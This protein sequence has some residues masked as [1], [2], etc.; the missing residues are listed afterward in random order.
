MGNKQLIGGTIFFKID[1]DIYKAKG[2]FKYGAGKPERE[3]VVGVDGVHGY[4][5]KPTAPFIE[6][7]L[8]DH[9]DLSIDD[10]ANITESTI[11][12]DLAN[13]KTF[14]LKQ[15]WNCNKDGLSV[16]ADDGKIGVRF[17]GMQGEE[18]K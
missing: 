9:G 17:E 14:V 3:A 16:E 13:G 5:E 8:T 18:V 11:T 12:I 4:T 10:L 6:G 7:E 15:A 1:G 2:G